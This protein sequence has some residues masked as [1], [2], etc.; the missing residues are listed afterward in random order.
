MV[1]PATIFIVTGALAL[2]LYASHQ[3]VSRKTRSV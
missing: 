3:I 2:T 1:I